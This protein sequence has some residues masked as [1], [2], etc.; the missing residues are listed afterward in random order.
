MLSYLIY[1][2]AGRRL[3]FAAAAALAPREAP[4]GEVP[5]G[6]AGPSGAYP[7]PG[8]RRKAVRGRRP[9][10]RAAAFAARSLRLAA[11]WALYAHVAFVGVT[12][13]LAFCYRYVDPPVTVLALSRKFADGFEI[14][15]PRPASLETTP[16]LLRRML[17]A[18]EDSRFY[19]HPGF[20]LEAF[21]RAAQ[22]NRE[23][24]QPMYGG[25]TL[26]MQLARTL[27]LVPAKSYL[28]KY[29]ELIVA[30]ELELILGK[31]RILELYLSWAEWGRGAFGIE[32][33][34][35][36]HYK[37]PASKLSFDEQARLVALLSSPIRY[38]PQDLE[39]RG[40][41]RARYEFLLKR[42]G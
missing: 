31:D 19:E 38:R 36:A 24:G 10:A 33:A 29:L 13:T 6:D 2:R 41:L 25:S 22:V 1:A 15:K 16:R 14:Q 20:D 28:R 32:A 17:I 12:A 37:K 21:K 18:A 11:V 8:R 40:I 26:T 9:P 34:A 3:R 39:R 35:R 4:S 23:I 7:P 30:V 27:F 5:P 42:F